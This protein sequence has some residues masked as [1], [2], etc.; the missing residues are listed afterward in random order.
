MICVRNE[1]GIRALY[2]QVRIIRITMQNFDVAFVL[3]ELPK[4]QKCQREPA[5][6][7]CQNATALANWRRKFEREVPRTTSQ[8]DNDVPR[9]QIQCLDNIGWSLPLVPFSLD[10]VQTRKGIETLV[11]RIEEEQDRYGAQKKNNKFD[12]VAQSAR[13][14]RRSGVPES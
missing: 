10:D 6:V 5:N 1:Y 8:I 4:P 11:S 12:T 2:R 14:P 7:L 3:Q 13:T 9:P